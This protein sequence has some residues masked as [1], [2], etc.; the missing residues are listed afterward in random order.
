MPRPPNPTFS[1]DTSQMDAQS[2]WDHF[3]RCL[4]QHDWSFQ[5]ADDPV[6]HR[7]GSQERQYLRALAGKLGQKGLDRLK[8]RTPEGC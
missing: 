3:E 6:Y 2:L 7:L 1:V 8:E 5:Y 4:D